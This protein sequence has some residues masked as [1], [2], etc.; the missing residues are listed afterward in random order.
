MGFLVG[1]LI[2]FALAAVYDIWTAGDDDLG[3]LY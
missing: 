2:G 1:C 3:D